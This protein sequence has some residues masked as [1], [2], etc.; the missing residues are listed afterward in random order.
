M[1]TANPFFYN[2]N[3]EE[4]L[5]TSKIEL[6]IAFIFHL[7][8]FA[9]AVYSFDWMGILAPVFSLLICVLTPKEHHYLKE[10]SRRSFNF[11]VFLTLFLIAAQTFLLML[12]LP[13][14]NFGNIVIRSMMVLFGGYMTMRACYHAYCKR[15]YEFPP[16]LPVF[17]K[18]Y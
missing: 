13:I 6:N 1:K 8:V 17:P 12:P 7:V 10:I 5:K 3:Y 16:S 4:E 18:Y 2:L 15:M 9:S 11:F 14:A